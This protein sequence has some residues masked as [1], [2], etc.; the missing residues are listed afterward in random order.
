MAFESLRRFISGGASKGGAPADAIN[1]FEID[2]NITRALAAQ[3]RLASAIDV[4]TVKERK[5]ANAL[6]RRKAA[7][8]VTSG[9]RTTLLGRLSAKFRNNPTLSVGAEGIRVGDIRLS[10]S[11]VGLSEKT[12]VG[13]GPLAFGVVAGQI[14]GTV[15]QGIVKARDKLREGATFEDF[16]QEF[17]AEAPGRIVSQV[18]DLFGLQNIAKGLISLISGTDFK[19]TEKMWRQAVSELW[20]VK[21]TNRNS[22]LNQL[23]NDR[24]EQKLIADSF[25]NSLNRD[26]KLKQVF[27]NKYPQSRVAQADALREN[28]AET[29]TDARLLVRDIGGRPV[30]KTLDVSLNGGQQ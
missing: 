30:W 23:D 1:S 8:A 27:L 6:S 26:K 20:D 18:A 10:R 11:G 24:D 25:Q 3:K 21:R 14:G 19:T 12:L 7:G 13:S 15:L 28:I 22:L 4:L 29:D 5:L 17:V 9:G 2:F 16:V